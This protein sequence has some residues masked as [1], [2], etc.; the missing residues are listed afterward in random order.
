VEALAARARWDAEAADAE[1]LRAQAAA[2]EQGQREAAAAAALLREA[3]AAKEAA[4]AAAARRLTEDVAGQQAEVARLVEDV[5]RAE[6]NPTPTPS[7]YP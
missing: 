5:W 6:Q 1:G 4:A 3:A 7:P 2:A